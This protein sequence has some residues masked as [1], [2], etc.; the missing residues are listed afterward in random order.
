MIKAEKGD[1]AK[2][3]LM[4]GD[5]LRAKYIAEKYLENAVLVND[6]RGMLGYTGTYKNKP[7]SVM[8]SGMGMPSMAIYSYE[9]FKF[10]DVENIIR[11]GTAGAIS[12]KLGLRD[13]VIAMSACTNSNFA[14]Q[15]GLSGNIA[16]TSSFELLKKAFETAQRLNKKVYVGSVYTTD[17]F[18]N[19]TDNLAD[20]RKLGILATEMECAALYLN[21]ARLGKNAL[22]ICTISD[23]PLTGES[24]TS[25]EREKTFNNMMEIALE[26]L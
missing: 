18:Y 12:D 22:C 13:I 20:W 6:V 14:A 7:V 26:S 24:C 19:D 8:A 9:L 21:A 15:Y 11:I 5:P 4:P 1:F 10:F 23:C 2:T 17:I 16:P 3:V 25:D